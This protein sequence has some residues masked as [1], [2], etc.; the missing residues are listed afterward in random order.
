MKRSQDLKSIL[1]TGFRTQSGFTNCP[2]QLL[3]H[4]ASHQQSTLL[5]QMYLSVLGYTLSSDA[6]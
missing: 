4:A 6:G 3:Q 5:Q 2:Q 1:V